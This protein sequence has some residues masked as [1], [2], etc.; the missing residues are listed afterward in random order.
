ME[1][2][3]CHTT[4]AR[5][6]TNLRSTRWGA[7]RPRGAARMEHARGSGAWQPGDMANHW[8]IH[9]SLS[10]E[11]TLVPVVLACGLRLAARQPELYRCFSAMPVAIIY[12]KDGV[13]HDDLLTGSHR[14]CRH[15]QMEHN[16]ARGSEK[17][18]TESNTLFAIRVTPNLI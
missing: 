11:K 12:P 1:E 18:I 16:D 3:E 15:Q 13:S 6:K 8:R 2:D 10:N 4:T 5:R 9:P 17:H 14:R 7:W